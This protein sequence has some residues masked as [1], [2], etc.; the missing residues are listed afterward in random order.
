MQLPNWLKVTNDA[1]ADAAEVIVSGFIGDGFWDESGSYAKRFRN[2]LNAIPRGRKINLKINSEGGVVK[3][4]LDMYD[5][6]RSRRDD[7]T[8]HIIGYACSCASW[9][10]LPAN[11]VVTSANA[12]WMI[13]KTSSGTWGNADEHAKSV[14]LLQK[15]DESI[16]GMLAQHTGKSVAEVTDAMAKETWFTGAEA[17]DYGLAD[18]VLD[19][20]KPSNATNDRR[21]HVLNILAAAAK[22]GT[23]TKPTG[24]TAPA[25]PP[26]PEA[27][28][29]VTAATAPISA[30][31]DGEGTAINAALQ[32]TPKAN[33]ETTKEKA[34][35]QTPPKEKENA[36]LDNPKG[37]E[38]MKQITALNE[39]LDAQEQKI[40]VL[41]A[42]PLNR[43][44]AQVVGDAHDKLIELK[45]DGLEGEELA[46]QVRNRHRH[47]VQAW[48]AIERILLDKTGANKE[49]RE[50][51][52]KSFQ[53]FN[54]QT[55]TN[56]N[57]ISAT[58][59]TALLSTTSYTVLQ[60]KLAALQALFLQVEPDR[61]KPLAKVE[62]PKTTAG[63][64]AQKNPTDWESGNC[65]VTNT[66][67]TVDEYSASQN[68]SNAD[69][70]SG[71]RMEW[72]SKITAIS[73]ANKII[74]ALE[75]F[76]LAATYTGTV[77]TIGAA[78]FGPGDLPGILALA[79]NF[80]TKNLVLDGAYTARL[81]PTSA[82]GLPW[83]AGQPA[84]GFDNIVEH[85]RWT[86]PAPDASVIGFVADP[87]ALP[88]VVGLPID[89]PGSNS[90]FNSLEVT[91][92][93]PLNFPVQVAS[94]IKPGTRVLW[95]AFD[96]MFGAAAGDAAGLNLIKSS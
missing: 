85:N 88:C 47:I 91:T 45:L 29:P 1:S 37:A 54:G 31:K 72:L 23:Q 9:F 51:N 76:L 68:L 27:T 28:P 21:N 78:N 32:P 56:A 89:P 90:A 71:S 30:A 33:M 75:A 39:K 13:H 63:P 43:V 26:T 84:Y 86:V 36:D 82:L 57:T 92:L 49:V 62:V 24:G 50:L 60:N 79:K 11:K 87:I 10:F 73:F 3:D 12:L 7:I 81:T 94:W 70:Q 14:E 52:G 18:E 83:S 96:A 35:D 19:E 46:K 66:E 53:A 44:R 69:L 42:P 5:A 58:L 67:I 95:M 61:L 65:T 64:T 40:K 41:E 77:T 17:K 4:G 2:E 34:A 6:I 55:V 16:A 25:V 22:E 15:H 20:A 59:T 48:S 93:A 8:A 38:L 74:D 80:M